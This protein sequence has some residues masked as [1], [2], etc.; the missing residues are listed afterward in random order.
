LIDELLAENFEEIDNGG[1]IRT[2]SDVIDWL[3][4]KIQLA[5]AFRD[6]RVKALTDDLVLAIIRCRNRINLTIVIQDLL[7]PRFAIPE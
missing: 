1:Q 3:K 4:T 5:L 7:E 6:F 2:R